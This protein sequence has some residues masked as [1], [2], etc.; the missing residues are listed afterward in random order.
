MKNILY[1]S[2]LVFVF[3][4]QVLIILIF[5]YQYVP[6]PMASIAE[7]VPQALLKSYQPN[8][9][10]FFYHAFIAAAIIGQTAVLYMFRKRLDSPDLATEIRTFLICETFW[11]L[12]QLFAMFKV[13]QNQGPGWAWVLWYAGFAAALLAKIFWPELNRSLKRFLIWIESDI[14][15]VW[16]KLADGGIIVLL[17]SVIAVPDTEKALLRL[18]IFD[19]NN[20]F[21]QWLMA[22]PLNGGA[23]VLV[24]FLAGFIG[25]VS[26][27]HV[28]GVL[29]FL[30]IIYYTA[31]YY[32]LR[33][34]LG[35]LPAAFGVLLA[36]KLQMFHAGVSPLIWIYPGQSILR[37]LSDVAL[38]LCLLFYSRGQW[39]IFLWLAGASVGLSLGL[40]FDTGLCMLGALYAYL[41]ALLVFKDTRSLLCPVPRQWR[42]VLG[43]GL[44]P[45]LVMVLILFFCFGSFVPGWP[46]GE[47]AVSIYSCLKDRNFFAFF[48]SFFPPLIYAAGIVVTVSMVSFRRWTFDKLFLIPLSVYGL[49]VYAIFLWHSS[50][51][52]YYMAPLPLV[53]CVCFWGTQV[54]EGTVK[55]R[56]LLVRLIFVFL[57]AIALFTNSIFTY[58][59]NVFNLS[60][61]NWDQEK[62]IYRANFNFKKEANF[63]WYWTLPG[64]RVAL[65]SS[66]ATQILMQAGRRPF[67]NGG[68]PLMGVE[69]IKLLLN[70]LDKNKPKQVFV[71][72]SIL[73]TSG[74]TPLNALI[75]YIKAHYQ[76]SGQQSDPLVLLT[77]KNEH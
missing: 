71:Q 20:H 42:K 28:I 58:Y 19:G 10:D 55:K 73:N 30:A 45:W 37:H 49:G 33:F 5:V 22:P 44:L 38:F 77:M 39:E 48:A 12:W 60:G 29:C 43:V 74:N 36:V 56:Q 57:A 53:G 51:N 2:L 64:S 18:A 32:L 62:S 31:F 61:E 16:Y 66:F 67:F 50:I 4:L 6:L 1:L 21:D 24:H 68:L 59:P 46:K 25:G 13:L 76:Y 8:R 41:A 14:P 15:G 23:P 69:D 26:Y 65:I 3:S 75:D 70:Q 35:V 17:L 47:N 54:L 52:Y 34:W 63:V 27:D 11:V 72:K 9:N 7:G 40:V